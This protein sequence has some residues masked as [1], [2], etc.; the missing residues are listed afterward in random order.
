MTPK[1]KENVSLGNCSGERETRQV[2]ESISERFVFKARRPL[3]TQV[4]FLREVEQ[5][6]AVCD[7]VTIRS[8]CPDIDTVAIIPVAVCELRRSVRPCHQLH[9]LEFDCRSAVVDEPG[10]R[11]V[12]NGAPQV[13]NLTVQLCLRQ[14][15]DVGWLEI[16]VNNPANAEK[17]RKL[18]NVFIKPNNITPKAGK[19]QIDVTHV[20][21][22][23]TYSPIQ[24][25]L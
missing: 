13:A 2:A 23:T 7:F 11:Q 19:Q 5:S 22:I 25:N 18:R 17:R 4:T 16:P 1:T 9:A 24:D 10:L 14:H 3:F 8:D 15:Q 12:E 6:A 20:N 21:L